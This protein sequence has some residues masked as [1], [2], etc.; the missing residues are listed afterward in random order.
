MTDVR[1]SLDGALAAWIDTL[2]GAFE[3]AGLAPELAII[4]DTR[5][6]ND[7]LTVGIHEAL[8]ELASEDLPAEHTEH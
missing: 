4:N 7:Q 5:D 1:T 8:E 2:A 6:I 3:A